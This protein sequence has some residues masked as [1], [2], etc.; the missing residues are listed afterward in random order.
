MVSKKKN[1]YEQKGYC[2]SI[3]IFESSAFKAA[4]SQIICKRKFG[5]SSC[6][7]RAVSKMPAPVFLSCHKSATCTQARFQTELVYRRWSSRSR[8]IRRNFPFVKLFEWT[9][10]TFLLFS[11][12][13]TKYQDTLITGLWAQLDISGNSIINVRVNIIENRIFVR[14]LHTRSYER[15]FLCDSAELSMEGW[16]G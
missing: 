8:W 4:K 16:F 3:L 7:C 2:S 11:R 15:F 12:A 14:T 1:V 5:Y 9:T 13:V 10:T 6:W